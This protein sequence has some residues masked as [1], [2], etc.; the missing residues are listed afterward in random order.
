MLSFSYCF[1]TE[2]DKSSGCQNPA[3][4]TY[5]DVLPGFE[6]ADVVVVVTVFHL[7]QDGNHASHKT[8]L[9]GKQKQ[10]LKVQSTR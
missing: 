2:S 9:G 5:N 1:L 6:G 8:S 4:T 3:K 10:K 7:P